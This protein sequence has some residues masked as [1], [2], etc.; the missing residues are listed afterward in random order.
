MRTLENSGAY[1]LPKLHALRELNPTLKVLDVGC[2]CGSVTASFAKTIG[3]QGRVVGV[4]VDP[5]KVQH[6]KNVAA[7]EGVADQVEVLEADAYKLPFA[8]AEFD[9][10]H[11]HQVLAHT[12]RPWD[13]LAE[14]L[15]V[16]KPGGIV[17]AREGD[18]DSEV[19][20]PVT[21][22]LEK[23][24]KLIA[25]AMNARGKG[26]GG[27]NAGRQLLPWALKI[28]VPRSKINFS[29]GTWWFD[30]AEHKEIW[31]NAMAD[32]VRSGQVREV[33]VKS[34]LVTEADLDE[35]AEAW[36]HWAAREDS[37]VAMMHGEI[38][39]AK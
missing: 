30:T 20:W 11:T 21:P 9:V 12:A 24:H 23:F 37:S 26:G 14:M 4:D 15:R 19:V 3:P 10:V 39:I 8:D 33:A 18:L 28:G 7:R 36:E 38:I 6:A 25:T 22:G 32:Q 5:A 31:A 27:S 34:G 29:F 17:V 1:F 16:T 2:G 35:M 13:V